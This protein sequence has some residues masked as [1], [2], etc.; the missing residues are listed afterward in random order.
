MLKTLSKES[1]EKHILRQPRDAR[2]RQ[3]RKLWFEK[4]C[5]TPSE[6]S[7]NTI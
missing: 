2:Q 4:Q 6:P 3:L 7:F 5:V 1:V